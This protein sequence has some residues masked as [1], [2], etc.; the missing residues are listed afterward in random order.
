MA[1]KGKARTKT[2]VKRVTPGPKPAY[3][4]VRPRFFAR[5]GV[6][7]TVGVIVGLGIFWFAIW[8]TNG[9]RQQ[10]ADKDEK[11]V[12]SREVAVVRQYVALVGPQLQKVGT[13]DQQ[14][15]GVFN[16][17]PDMTQVAPA[18]QD[19]S[20]QPAQLIKTFKTLAKADGDAADAIGKIDLA[21][22]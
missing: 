13:Q 22:R 19:K 21:N 1:I 5:K 16:L 2:K 7:W 4:P 6:L 10:Q 20:V 15:P 12:K 9:L 18:M 11:A 17:G 3:V 14:Q 8:L